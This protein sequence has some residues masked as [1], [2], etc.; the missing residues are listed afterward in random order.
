MG[1]SWISLVNK[2]DMEVEW[3]IIDTLEEL[4]YWLDV[5]CGKE[6]DILNDDENI[7]I[8]FRAEKTD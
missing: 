7:D 1:T 8:L 6:E 4:Q 3:L 2:S 5:V